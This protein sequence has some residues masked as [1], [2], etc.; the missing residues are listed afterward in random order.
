MKNENRIMFKSVIAS[1]IAGIIL[2]IF[3]EPILNGLW[4]YIS[5]SSNS[6]L[7]NITNS[8]Y[9]N[10]ALGIRNWLDFITISLGIIILVFWYIQFTA[11]KMI[12]IQRHIE[13]KK[14][15]NLSEED[16]KNKYEKKSI[17]NYL[18]IN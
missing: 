13:E 4:K 8:A 9:R 12:N 11:K 15:E 14:D 17:G 7:I 16:L 18:S 5:F 2:I 6:I 3:L 10:A 1:L